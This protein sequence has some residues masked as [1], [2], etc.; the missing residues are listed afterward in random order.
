M[1]SNIHSSY[2]PDT[3]LATIDD[4]CI[5][6]RDLDVLE[7]PKAW[8]TAS[9]LL[10]AMRKRRRTDTS[11]NLWMDPSVVSFLVG[12]CHDEDDV[13]DFRAGYGNFQGVRRILCPINDVFGAKNQWA[14]PG[15]GTHWSLLWIEVTEGEKVC[16][17]HADSVASRPN[18]RAARAVATKWAQVLSASEDMTIQN[19][20]VP[21]QENGYDCGVHVLAAMEES[22]HCVHPRELETRLWDA[23]REGASVYCRELRRSVAVDIRMLAEKR[24]D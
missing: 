17:W 7:S 8:L 12:Q 11:E 4:A 19:L 15:A 22:V 18:G 16:F 9:C 24:C 20:E 5:Y 23:M 6:G 14:T 13:R 10:G 3:L 21:L 1:P 2:P